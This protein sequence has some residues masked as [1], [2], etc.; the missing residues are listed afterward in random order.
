VL[1]SLTKM[2]LIF[3]KYCLIVEKLGIYLSVGLIKIHDVP[4]NANRP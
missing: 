2:L 3:P 1:E 4:E